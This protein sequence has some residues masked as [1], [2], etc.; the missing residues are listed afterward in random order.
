V[1]G[2]GERCRHRDRRVR[3]AVLELPR[4]DRDSAMYREA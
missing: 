3:E 1:L 2:R 4:D